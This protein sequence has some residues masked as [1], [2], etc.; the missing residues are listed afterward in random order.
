MG[1]GPTPSISAVTFPPLTVT[2]PSTTRLAC[3]PSPLFTTMPLPSCASASKCT[4]PER[5]PLPPSDALA[6]AVISPPMTF[7]CPVKSIS[8]LSASTS[9]PTA[10]PPD[11][12]SF[13][14][15]TAAPSA[16][17]AP[18]L[19]LI[20]VTKTSPPSIVISPVKS[21]LT[22]S[23]RGRSSTNSPFTELKAGINIPEISE[24][25]A[26]ASAVLF[27]VVAVTSAPP[28]VTE[29]SPI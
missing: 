3:P 4:S 17:F 14:I 24:C 1:A 21:I 28:P 19:V 6:L 27:C 10:S 7:T 2:G 25:P 5:T 18:V 16:S 12:K 26:C 23:N 15:A 9:T 13:P 20:A 11:R 22:F 8:I 29:I